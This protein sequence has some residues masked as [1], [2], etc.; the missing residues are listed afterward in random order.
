MRRLQ[1]GFIPRL[2]R[3]C[4]FY[5]ETVNIYG[6]QLLE[7][8][9]NALKFITKTINS[10]NHIDIAEVQQRSVEIN[11]AVKLLWVF[12]MY[13]FIFASIQFT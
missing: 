12:W 10:W 13:F 6:G 3:L 9:N 1:I 8:K 7:T 2:F 5:G 4:D 11:G